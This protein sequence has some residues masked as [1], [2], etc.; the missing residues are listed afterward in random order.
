MILKNLGVVIVRNAFVGVD[1]LCSRET[2]AQIPVVGMIIF[3]VVPRV[4]S[5]AMNLSLRLHR[6]V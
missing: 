4:Q 1:K 5:R 6:S 3:R 2:R